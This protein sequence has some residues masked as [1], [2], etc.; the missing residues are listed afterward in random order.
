MGKTLGE[1]NYLTYISS[2]QKKKT[3]D[4]RTPNIIGL[5]T[6]DQAREK[7]QRTASK[8]SYLFLIFFWALSD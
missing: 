4:T 8:M 5:L 1:I 6:I 2:Y 3:K 7:A